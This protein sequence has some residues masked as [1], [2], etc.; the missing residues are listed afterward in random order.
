MI[1]LSTDFPAIETTIYIATAP[2]T[3]RL[4]QV[5]GDDPQSEPTIAIIKKTITANFA[6]VARIVF[7]V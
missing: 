1:I 7:I 2:M 6:A 3:A 4:Q 5:A